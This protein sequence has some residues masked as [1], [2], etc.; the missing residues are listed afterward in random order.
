MNVRIKCDLP[1]SAAIYY[2][3]QFRVNH[4]S[5]RLWMTTN[6]TDASTH[7]IALDRIKYFVYNELDSTVFIYSQNKVQCEKFVAAGVKIT[8]L[9]TEPVDQIVGIMLYHKLNAIMEQHMIIVETEI[10]SALGDN[11][12]YL[13]S[14]N[15][16]IDA[17]QPDS[18]WLT[19]DLV[20]C[21]FSWLSGDKVL[22]L[23]QA[24]AWRDLDLAWPDLVTDTDAGNVLVFA[25]FK[26]NDTK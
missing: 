3:D 17:I 19:P 8:T 10:S 18:W 5:L 24:N 25:D 23:P 14:E 22:S 7:N 11:I 4:F 16:L 20:H 1:F 9:P 2:N 6:H 21:D 26:N 12:T 15:E 13:H